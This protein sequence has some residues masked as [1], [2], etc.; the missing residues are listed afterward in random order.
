MPAKP[1]ERFPHQ[2]R[3]REP[4]V[5]NLRPRG[6]TLTGADNYSGGVHVTSGMLVVAG[7]LSLIRRRGTERDAQDHRKIRRGATLNPGAAL[8]L[9]GGA[10]AT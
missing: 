3:S 8:L 4:A 10:A 6:L 5:D 7:T 1:A 9:D 2:F